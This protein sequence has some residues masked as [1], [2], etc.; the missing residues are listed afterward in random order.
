MERK[1]P[2]PI[3]LQGYIPL[4][5]L[6][7]L[8]RDALRACPKEERQKYCKAL[9]QDIIR[10]SSYSVF[11]AIGLLESA[12]FYFLQQAEDIREKEEQNAKIKLW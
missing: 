7:E 12:Q 1:K 8:N 11:E 9:T 4:D 10:W 3:K 2:H 6:L 5:K